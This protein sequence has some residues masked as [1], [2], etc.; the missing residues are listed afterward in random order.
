MIM[1]DENSQSDLMGS[2]N[3]KMTF[4]ALSLE[5]LRENDWTSSMTEQ[6]CDNGLGFDLLILEIAMTHIVEIG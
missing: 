4:A 6:T 3:Q 2:E 5:M 1:A